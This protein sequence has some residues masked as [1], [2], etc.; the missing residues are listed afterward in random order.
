MNSLT[1]K[2]EAMDVGFGVEGRMRGVWGAAGRLVDWRAVGF[3][4]RVAWVS[5]LRELYSFS[6]DILTFTNYLNFFTHSDFPPGRVVR[7]V[8]YHVEVIHS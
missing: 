6:R 1:V 8:G 3:G 2:Y 4:P 5:A 7:C